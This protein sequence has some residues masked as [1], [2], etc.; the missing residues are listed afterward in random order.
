MENEGLK[1]ITEMAQNVLTK[2]D[3]L[4][5]II[6]SFTPKNSECHYRILEKLAISFKSDLKNLSSVLAHISCYCDQEIDSK[7]FD[8]YFYKAI[9]IIHFSYPT[10]KANGLKI[11]NEISKFNKSKIY[12]AS[13]NLQR[14]ADESWWEIKAQILIICAN[15]LE[16][17]ENHDKGGGKN[18]DI[19]IENSLDNKHEDSHFNENFDKKSFNS[20]YEEENGKNGEINQKSQNRANKGQKSHNRDNADMS[21]PEAKISEE[22]KRSMA[23][24]SIEQS[25]Y[26]KTE[27]EETM[28]PNEQY[29]QKLID[30]VYKIFHVHQNINVQKVGLVY[31]AKIL[32]YYPEL[33]ERYLAV[34]LSI[35]DEVKSS[36]LN[37]DDVYNVESHIVL[38][39][40]FI[41]LFKVFFLVLYKYFEIF[42]NF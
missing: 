30:I 12:L 42:L 3:M 9:K 14:L 15:Q 31:L 35:N 41:F 13:D 26:K 27:I 38:C 19:D 34:L 21:A 28:V 39:K 29:I 8:F 23:N 24:S 5:H 20:E 33:C 32:N 16:F 6:M 18:G 37:N 2:R 25:M 1:Q 11:L 22:G 7:I 40:I 10:M 36:I 17:I 4:A